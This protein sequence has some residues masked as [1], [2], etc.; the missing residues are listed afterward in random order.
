MPATPTNSTPA[1]PTCRNYD[2]ARLELLPN[3]GTT[4]SG[5]DVEEEG[6]LYE[7][8][9]RA[10]DEEANEFDRRSPASSVFSADIYL[11][12]NRGS[13]AFAK[14]VV[15]SGW[16]TVAGDRVPSLQKG[17][18]LT[19]VGS[20]AYIVYDCVV[21]TKES[22]TFHVLKR[23]SDFEDLDW[24][25]RKTLPVALQPAIPRLPP[26]APFARFRP[27][28]LDRRRQHLQFWLARV[29][30]HPEIGQSDAVKKW[31]MSM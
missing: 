28:F 8:L 4:A 9:C 16:T 17:K 12:D 20:G 29:L 13:G 31:V 14:D 2:N 23:Y 26:K 30:L 1:T 21:T 7:E 19:G 27:V 6:R 22:T 3:S 10:Y 24:N 25:L 5:I 18:G 15:I 11:S